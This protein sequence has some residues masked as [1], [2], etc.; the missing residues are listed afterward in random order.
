MSKPFNQLIL[1]AAIMIVVA[2]ALIIMFRNG[3]LLDR[4]RF[5]IRSD[6]LA[7]NA[8]LESEI[9]DLEE[10]IAQL[11]Q[12]NRHLKKVLVGRTFRFSI[13]EQTSLVEDGGGRRNPQDP[14]EVLS[15][16]STLIRQIYQALLAEKERWDTYQQNQYRSVLAGTLE[17]II[18]ESEYLDFV[19][20]DSRDL[21]LEIENTLYLHRRL[22][23]DVRL[24]HDEVIY[25]NKRN[26]EGSSYELFDLKLSLEPFARESAIT[27][28]LQQSLS[29]LG[30]GVYQDEAAET[31]ERLGGIFVAPIQ[32]LSDWLASTDESS[33]PK[34]YN[35]NFYIVFGKKLIDYADSLAEQTM[36]PLAPSALGELDFFSRRIRQSLIRLHEAGS[37]SLIDDSILDLEV[38]EREMQQ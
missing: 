6:L 24:F 36:I 8:K 11:A 35:Y 1:W 7:E 13:L 3:G 15:A 33:G 2:G 37:Q 12:Q 32:T 20:A 17:P 26:E 29:A 25:R 31:L 10:Q 30:T 27:D 4:M 14:S 28:A 19:E 34:P 9:M 16:E 21:F 18:V 5:Q 38:L 23:R 22:I